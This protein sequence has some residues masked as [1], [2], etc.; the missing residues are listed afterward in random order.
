MHSEFSIVDSTVRI[1]DAVAAA[2]AD[3]MPA[4]ALT[5]LANLFGMVKFYK[6]ARSKGIKPIVGCDVEV[7]SQTAGQAPH[8][9]LLL[10]QNREGYLRLCT[11]LT[12]A[13]AQPQQRGTV[14]LQPAWFSEG[15]SGLIA[16]SGAPGGPHAGELGTLLGL[17]HENAALALARQW[18]QWFPG[19]YYIELQ[20][21]GL[22][23]D[24]DANAA[25]IDLAV[26]LD[27]P[28]VATHPVQ[29]LKSDDYVAHEAR[30]CIAE[31][32]I[33]AD[34]RRQRRFTSDQYFKSQDEMVAL[35]ADCP[36][37]LLN[38]VELAK[39]CSVQIE[40]GRNY[41]PAFPTPPGVTLDE[42]LRS[43]AAVGLD[44]RLAYRY[45]DPAVRAGAE[46]AYRERLEF[47]LKTIVQMGFAGYFLIVADFINWARN[48]G[49]PVGPGRGSGAGSLVAYSLGITDLDPLQYK[50]LFERFLN[51]E[52]IS[53]PDFDID[54][55]QDG[56]DKVID[57]V[58]RKYGA[59]S[60]S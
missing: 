28:V 13:Y 39:R 8:R 44:K 23:D 27:L 31:G 12:R 56:R 45:R 54:F 7:D 3:G 16:L 20:R 51:P 30:V 58:R 33:L 15:T 43:E 55:C 4:L 34:Q 32:A 6:A 40:L 17:D 59:D 19:R 26:R 14:S 52:R 25:A 29:F 9:I 2:Q 10:C 18:A 47:E 60:V 5:D 21:A 50:L 38:A 24:D 37:A 22:P 36:E 1:D 57:Y 41:L 46:S 11:W 42:H 35:F 48:N 49:V 53:M